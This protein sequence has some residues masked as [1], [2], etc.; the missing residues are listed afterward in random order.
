MNH[1]T[2]MGRIATEL[3]LKTT[4]QGTSVISFTLAVPRRMKKDTT[5]F[6]KCIAWR[7]EA[8][9]I[10][11][12]FGKGRMIALEGELQTRQWEG[13]DGKKNFATE[14][15]VDRV[16][17]TGEKATDAPAEPTGTFSTPASN[18]WA[19]VQESDLPF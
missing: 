4:Q 17:F 15:V 8:E 18:A 1:I 16:Y 12:Y 10:S 19:E 7:N 2:L 5:D 9:F 6:I 3:E 13:Q 11:K 14:V